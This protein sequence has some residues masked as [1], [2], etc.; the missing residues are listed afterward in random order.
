MCCHLCS[1]PHGQYWSLFNA[2]LLHREVSIEVWMAHE[3]NNNHPE[4]EVRPGCQA[5]PR[6]DIFLTRAT[7]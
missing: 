7:V 3:R 4:P 2:A 5:P 1:Q 6:N